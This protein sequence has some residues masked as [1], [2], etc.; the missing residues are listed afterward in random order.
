[1]LD[2]TQSFFAPS[3]L[4]DKSET[5]LVYG[6]K[7]RLGIMPTMD[8]MVLEPELNFMKPDGIAIYASRL[9]KPS[10]DTNIETQSFAVDFLEDAVKMLAFVNPKVICLGSTS[11]SFVR[12]ADQTKKLIARIEQASGGVPGTTISDSLVHGLREF[13]AKRV[14]VVTPYV[15]ELNVRERAFLEANDFEVL[16]I[17]GFQLLSSDDICNL[18]PEAIYDFALHHFDSRADTLLFSCTGLHTAPLMDRVERHYRKPLVSSNAAAL[19]RMLRIVGVK[20]KVKG[21]GSLLSEH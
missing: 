17:D 21:F 18:Q 10:K 20:E 5:I 14:S 4:R 11:S 13:G 7:A 8:D 12:G 3:I 1:M 19:W 6:W 2:S 15:E 16:N 9:K